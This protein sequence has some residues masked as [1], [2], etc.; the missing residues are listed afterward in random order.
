MSL[1]CDICK[2]DYFIFFKVKYIN[3][4]ENKKIV[5]CD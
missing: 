4:F 3:F 2:G 5:D 1:L